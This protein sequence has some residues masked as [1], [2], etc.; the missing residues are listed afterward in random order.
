MDIFAQTHFAYD[1]DK[2]NSEFLAFS[3]DLVLFLSKVSFHFLVTLGQ[4]VPSTEGQMLVGSTLELYSSHTRAEENILASR[5]FTRGKSCKRYPSKLS[6]LMQRQKEHVQ[7]KEGAS[8]S[9]TGPAFYSK[10][11]STRHSVFVRYSLF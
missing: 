11:G 6:Q 2:D 5:P 7:T 4:L 8:H 3:S 9:D 1:K 10:F